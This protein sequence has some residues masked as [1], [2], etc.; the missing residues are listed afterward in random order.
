MLG[1]ILKTICY[2]HFRYKPNLNIWLQLSVSEKMSWSAP[3][4]LHSCPPSC[5]YLSEPVA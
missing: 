3:N 4:D 5:L 1:N 2:E